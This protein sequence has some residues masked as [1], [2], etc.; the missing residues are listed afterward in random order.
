MHFIDVLSSSV[1]FEPQICAVLFLV[2]LNLLYQ[3]E[4]YNMLFQVSKVPT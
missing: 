4:G 3:K 1:T 2:D